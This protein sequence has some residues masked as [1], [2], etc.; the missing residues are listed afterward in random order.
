M[1]FYL[2]RLYN[3]SETV[4]GMESDE[5]TDQQDEGAV[6]GEGARAARPTCA[7][8]PWK[9]PASPTRTVRIATVDGEQT[10]QVS[11]SQARASIQ[12]TVAYI[13]DLHEEILEQHG[14]V[15]TNIMNTRIRQFATRSRLSLL[16]DRGNR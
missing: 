3:N 5:E 8:A 1:R 10:L 7:V 2:E 15:M 4:N 11:D 14:P 9:K 6:G 12:V 13:R 16:N